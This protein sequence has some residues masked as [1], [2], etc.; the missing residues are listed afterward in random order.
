MATI[1]RVRSVRDNNND[2]NVSPIVTRILENSKSFGVST[3]HNQINTQNGFGNRFLEGAADADLEDYID[4]LL[5]AYE[6]LEGVDIREDIM[7]AAKQTMK[8]TLVGY[9]KMKSGSKLTPSS[10]LGNDVDMEDFAGGAVGWGNVSNYGHVTGPVIAATLP[11]SYASQTLP[12]SAMK[13]PRTT[14]EIDID[15]VHYADGTVMRAEDLGYYNEK[16]GAFGKSPQATLSIVTDVNNSYTAD[17]GGGTLGLKVGVAGV[18][19]VAATGS[20]RDANGVRKL[21]DH[22]TLRIV[23]VG[24]DTNAGDAPEVIACDIKPLVADN[25]TRQQIFMGKVVKD[26]DVFNITVNVID[27]DS[28]DVVIMS[29]TNSTTHKVTGIV[30]YFTLR[31]N[32]TAELST[33]QRYHREREQLLIESAP[34]IHIPFEPQASEDINALAGIDDVGTQIEKARVLINQALETRTIRFVADVITKGIGSGLLSKAKGEAGVKD[35][36]F[37]GEVNLKPSANLQ[38]TE[39]I[40]EYAEMKFASYI[41]EVIVKSQMTTRDRDV[42]WYFITDPLTNAS[43]PKN[44]SKV[45][46][47]STLGKASVNV[48]KDA[49]KMYKGNDG[50]HDFFLVESDFLGVNVNMYADGS[51]ANGIP[52]SL[53][54]NSME[55]AENKIEN[56]VIYGFAVPNKMGAAGDPDKT[57]E[58]ITYSI[59]MVEGVVSQVDGMNQGVNIY[60]RDLFTNFRPL[61]A[62][63]IVKNIDTASRYISA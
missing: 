34:L 22:A 37:V 8:T 46:S 63:I 17:L 59:N 47:G 30:P 43:I 50:Q 35:F 10:L 52:N 55:D 4:S 32:Q 28:G 61:V 38:N 60:N 56:G 5:G 62:K 29:S 58:Y 25:D 9:H 7:A 2:N 19:L 54:S 57:L 11:I 14:F 23:G 16:L 13:T 42:T 27:I 24:I 44:G 26:S 33:R 12:T 41:R 53:R 21:Y 40:A 49:I 45:I 20:V 31:N 6:E 39:S 36:V 1:N 51:A 48:A 18:N 15:T 3:G